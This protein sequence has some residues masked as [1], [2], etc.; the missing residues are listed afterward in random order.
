MTSP[1]GSMYP[2]IRYL[3]FWVIAIIVLVFGKSMII[4]YLD[5]LTPE[6]TICRLRVPGDHAGSLVSTVLRKPRTRFRCRFISSTQT[7]CFAFRVQGLG[8]AFLG[9][10]D[11]DFGEAVLSEQDRIL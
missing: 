11:S 1:K 10:G 8:Y 9:L 5:R 7:P 6:F 2:I 4:W 3:R